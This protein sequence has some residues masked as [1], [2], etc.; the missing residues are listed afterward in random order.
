[1]LG[2]LEIESISSLLSAG[3]KP[4]LSNGVYFTLEVSL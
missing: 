3:S 2:I 4:A 1:M